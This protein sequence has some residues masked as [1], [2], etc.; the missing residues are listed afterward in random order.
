M[1]NIYAIE[2]LGGSGKTVLVKQ[3]SEMGFN[4]LEEISET[5]S[6]EERNKKLEN[7]PKELR[8]RFLNDWYLE[9]EIERTNCA[10]AKKNI[11]VFDRSIYSQICYVFAQD[12]Y[13]K[14]NELNYLLD[15]LETSDCV[16]PNLI[17][18]KCSVDFALKG[19]YERNRREEREKLAKGIRGYARG[20]LEFNKE[21]YEKIIHL[22]GDNAL[23][24][25]IPEE[26]G[27]LLDK[28]SKWISEERNATNVDVNKIREVLCN[29]K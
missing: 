15:K 22:L 6:K 28:V 21:A 9:R 19:I 4:A 13:Y 24:I 11:V 14:T 12:N 7:M 8:P 2:G 10:L 5:I 23:T 1:T 18:L 26:R 25:N 29:G 16:F 3:L 27:S 20:F 17:Y